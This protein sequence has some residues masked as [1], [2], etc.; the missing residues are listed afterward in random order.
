MLTRKVQVT[1]TVEVTVD[2]ATFTPEFMAEFRQFF[3]PFETL[4]E[5]LEHLAQLHAR[6]IASDFPHAFIEGYGPPKD[7][8]IRFEVTDQTEEV[9]P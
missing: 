8:G 3:F 4:D 7:M 5:H 2:E 6:G 9:I 1:Q